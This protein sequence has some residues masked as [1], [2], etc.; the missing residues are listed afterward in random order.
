MRV[1]II[2]SYPIKG[3]D[4]NKIIAQSEDRLMNQYQIRSEE[5]RNLVSC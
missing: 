5:K 4:P 2:I 1:P 3:H